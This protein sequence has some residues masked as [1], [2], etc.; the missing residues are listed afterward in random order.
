MADKT[1]DDVF[2]LLDQWRHFPA[3]Q[4]ERRADIYFAMFLPEVLEARCKTEFNR[5]VI[6]EFPLKKSDSNLSNKADYFA[7]SKVDKKPFL[8]EL[9]TDMNSLIDSQRD[10]LCKASKK[11]LKTL[12]GEIITIS[13]S[14]NTLHR[15]KYAHL[16]YYLSKLGLVEVPK[17]ALGKATNKVS[18]S[19]KPKVIYVLPKESKAIPCDFAQITFH[20]F[21]NAIKGRGWIADRFAL[22]LLEW[23]EVD[24]GSVPP[25]AKG[26]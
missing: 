17:D 7:L 2:E 16:L 8:V 23:A 18:W 14:K 26:P 12:I 1:I 6:P 10:Y 25:G 5:V 22:S 13:S 9:K 19:I 24:A 11:D 3:Y 4:L 15:P 21:A 20:D